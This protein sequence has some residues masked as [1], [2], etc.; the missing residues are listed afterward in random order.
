[1]PKRKP[2]DTSSPVATL[3]VRAGLLSNKKAQAMLAALSVASIQLLNVLVRLTGT[4]ALVMVPL[5]ALVLTNAFWPTTISVGAD[6]V[7]VAS[8]ARR[9]FYPFARVQSATSSA[10]GVMLRLKG[11]RE[12]EIRTEPKANPGASAARAALLARIVQ[13]LAAFEK[14]EARAN[15]AVL[16]ARGGRTVDEWMRA[17]RALGGG[18]AGGYRAPSIPT[19]ELWRVLEDPASDATARAGAAVA[20]RESLDD[21][22]RARLRLAAEASASP[23]VRVALEA[24]GSA[25]DEAELTRALSECE[26]QDPVGLR[27]RVIV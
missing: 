2:A 16:V 25:T 10:W 8:F 11:G 7:L 26:E 21:G 12:V 17:L 27:A 22:G 6:G 13:R 9:A 23:K 24:A 4:F 14:Q 15:T 18:D 5:L 1:V 3:R 19:E 20:L